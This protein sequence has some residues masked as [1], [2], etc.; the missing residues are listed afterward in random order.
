MI[1]Y[2]NTW[3]HNMNIY[4]EC[5]EQWGTDKQ[6]CQAMGECGEFIAEAQNYRRKKV[7]LRQ[8]LSEAADAHVMMMQM[9]ELDPALFDELKEE[10]LSKVR[11]QLN[12]YK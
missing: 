9:R 2:Q 11:K 5:L 8:M 1:H 3:G 7:S 6:I 12:K 4:Q 10:S